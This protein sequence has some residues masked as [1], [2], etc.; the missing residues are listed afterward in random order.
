MIGVEG[1]LKEHLLL[2][3]PLPL[4]QKPAVEWLAGLEQAVRFSLASRLTDCLSR[5]PRPLTGELLTTEEAVLEW[6]SGH[7]QQTILLALD[8]HWSSRLLQACS[9]HTHSSLQTLQLVHILIGYICVYAIIYIL[10]LVQLTATE[11][12]GEHCTATAE[13]HHPTQCGG[14][15]GR[16]RQESSYFSCTAKCDH[17]PEEE[18]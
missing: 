12:Y 11:S 1:E 6:L 5:L 18:V 3:L 17:L 8:I 13:A 10:T 2:V 7:V 16:R 9:D 4:E 15:R 14:R